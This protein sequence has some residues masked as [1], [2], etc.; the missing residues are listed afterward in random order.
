MFLVALR[1]IGAAA[2]REASSPAAVMKNRPVNVAITEASPPAAVVKHCP[3]N[4][5][6]TEAS[7]P[8]ALTKHKP[9]RTTKM[10]PH[11]QETCHKNGTKKAKG[12]GKN[13]NSVTGKINSIL[14]SVKI[15]NKN[16]WH[17]LKSLPTHRQALAFVML[18]VLCI[19]L[20][21]TVKTNLLCTI[22][23]I[24]NHILIFTL[25]PFSIH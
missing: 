18:Y 4:V 24:L 14:C 11:K 20:N 9:M 25:T 13:A 16:V 3:V 5:A 15:G 8:V 6:A 12:Q 22:L 19:I 1:T 10:A 21:N 17:M 23:C 7:S 2:I